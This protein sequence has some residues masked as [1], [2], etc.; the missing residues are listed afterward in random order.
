MED[1]I[2][3]MFSAVDE[4]YPGSKRKRR[5][6]EVVEK[7]VSEEKSWDS[8][9]YVKTLNGED[10]EFFTVGALAD[11]LGRPVIT[12]RTWTMEGQLPQSP[13]RL[14]PKADKNGEIRLGRRLYTR[15]MIEAAIE[16]FKANGLLYLNKI[17]WSKNRHI[18][19][20]VAEAWSKLRTT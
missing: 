2:D 12:V 3:E 16:I 13:Y 19:E 10:V 8:R 1:F 17:D 4:Y 6:V 15:A 9:P 18:P 20:D 7:K 5:D 14:P 11:A